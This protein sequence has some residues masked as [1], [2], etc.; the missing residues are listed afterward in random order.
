MKRDPFA[1][2]I[3]A[4]LGAGVQ[5]LPLTVLARLEE[6]RAQALAAHDA[7]PQ[8]RIAAQPVLSLVL[9]VGVALAML[10][11]GH[12]SEQQR[13]DVVFTVGQYRMISAAL[14]TFGV[15]IED[16][17]VE[18]FPPE[19]FASGPFAAGTEEE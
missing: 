4:E 16:D 8:R 12:W 17:V 11:G 5:A 1:A 6:A 10:A 14:N 13:M 7:T 19:L 3:G 2:R 18:R 15:Q 9:A